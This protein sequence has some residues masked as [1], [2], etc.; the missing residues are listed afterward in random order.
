MD[1]RPRP[2]NQNIVSRKQDPGPEIPDLEPSRKEFIINESKSK[3]Q[4]QDLG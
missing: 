3:T 4:I 1:S 2:W